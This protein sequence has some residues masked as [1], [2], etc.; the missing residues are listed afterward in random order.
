MADNPHPAS[1]RDPA[2]HVFLRDDAVYRQVNRSYQADYE[3]LMSS[4]LYDSLTRN[5]RLL[6][7]A[8]TDLVGTDD[9]AWKVIRPSQLSFIS[10]PYEWCFSQLK[11]A[12]LLTLDIQRECMDKGMSLKDAT[13][14]NVTFNL[15]NKPVFIDTLSFETYRP[16]DP[17]IAYHQFCS[18]FLAPLLLA[19]RDGL[20]PA[21]LRIVLNPTPDLTALPLTTFYAAALPTFGDADGGGDN[22][23]SVSL[24]P[25]LAAST[26]STW[27]SSSCTIAAGI[28]PP[29]LSARWCPSSWLVTQVA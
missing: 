25:T 12:A 9:G 18:S 6:P 16:E 8:E 7:H 1:Y 11:E 21:S 26:C 22:K 23:T 15:H 5:G 4:G 27:S 2:G 10:Y 29:G 13:P 28:S 17:W 3:R 19:L 14:F 24:P 20:A